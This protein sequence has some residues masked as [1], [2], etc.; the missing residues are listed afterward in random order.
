MDME[1]K[2]MS[3]HFKLYLMGLMFIFILTTV[4]C[5]RNVTTDNN[6]INEPEKIEVQAKDSIKLQFE[7]ENFTFHSFDKDKECIEDLTKA[8]DEN[9]DTITNNYKVSLKDKV[10]IVIY[11]NIDAFHNNMGMQNSPDWVAGSAW[12]NEIYMVSPLNPGTVHTY[13]SLMKVIVH[14]FVHVVQY[15]IYPYNYPKRWLAEGLASYEA[16]QI[17]NKTIM[18][19]KI[20]G[21][22]I[23]TLSDMNSKNFA[24]NDGYDFSYT[25]AEYLVKEYGYEPIIDMIK[26]PQKMEEILGKSLDEFE[27]DWINYLKENW[28]S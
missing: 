26:T 4:A 6:E 11:S 14:E 18:K 15:D 22:K 9:Y 27:K 13:D 19:V 25:V 3:R 17:P 28:G 16:G 23:P 5:N 8:L 24:E 1:G 10:K 12:R 20:D 21:G 7:N 2:H